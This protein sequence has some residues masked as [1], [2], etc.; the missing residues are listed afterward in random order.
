VKCGVKYSL[1]GVSDVGSD[2]GRVRCYSR[3]FITGKQLSLS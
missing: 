3:S 1:Q 2:G